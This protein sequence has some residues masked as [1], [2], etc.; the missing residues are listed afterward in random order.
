MRSRWAWQNQ[1]LTELA[2]STTARDFAL[3]A[4]ATLCLLE[5][6]GELVLCDTA[7]EVKNG[8]PHTTLR[9]LERISDLHALLTTAR[10]EHFS[11][12]FWNQQT[13][14]DFSS[15]PR[16]KVRELRLEVSGD[17]ELEEFRDI[18]N[19]K[20]KVARANYEEMMAQLNHS[21]SND[22]IDTSPTYK[23]LAGRMVGF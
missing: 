10:D 14:L 16:Q 6:G 8:G 15:I 18:I 17:E 7:V 19:E 23:A 11:R 5:E 4:P 1:Q 20:L 13:R 3:L 9:E 22:I 2:V 21:N 12:L